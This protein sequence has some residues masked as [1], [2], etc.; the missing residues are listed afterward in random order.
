MKSMLKNITMFLAVNALVACQNSP[1]G[2]KSETQKKEQVIEVG[3]DTLCKPLEWTTME[4]D[5]DIFY[6]MPYADTANFTHTKLYPCAKCQLRPSVADA[7]RKASEEAV[8]HNLRLLVYD[9]Y[10]PYSVQVKMF[11]I[12]GNE[13][14]VAKPGKGSNHN[15]GCAVDLTLCDKQGRALDMGTR[16]DDFSEKAAYAYRYLS[17]EQKS[18]RTLLRSIMQYAG[19]EPFESEWWHFNYKDLNYPVSNHSLPCD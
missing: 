19:F 5:A 17:K 18:N 9:C 13:K 11:E 2:P 8:K 16:F 10:R 12:V 7:L 6:R 14:Y 15:K 3:K 1:S 4:Q